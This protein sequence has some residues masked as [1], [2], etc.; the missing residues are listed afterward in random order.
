MKT[1]DGGRG[2][3]ERRKDRRERER[4]VGDE[5]SRNYTEHLHLAS[6]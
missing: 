3:E 5:G 4:E 2:M 1:G 6:F